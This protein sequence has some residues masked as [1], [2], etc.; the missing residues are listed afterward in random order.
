MPT[1]HR[2]SNAMPSSDGR[3]SDDSIL[4]VSAALTGAKSA[5]DEFTSGDAA[6]RISKV[7]DLVVASIRAGGK[8]L[9]CGNGG[10][11]CDAT[12]FAEELTGRFRADRPALPA[13]AISDAGHITCTAND[14]GFDRVFSRGVEAL[15]KAGDVLIVLST[16]GN[17]K[18][19]VLAV[20]AARAK[21]LSVVA[22]LGKTGG[23]LKGMADVELIAPGATADRIQELHM[24]VLHTIVEGVEAAMF[25]RS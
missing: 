16:S 4:L 17:S 7:I 21:G 9:I 3:P 24:I 1:E 19:V 11:L 18:N 15:G 14:Y 25:G 6:H 23:A 12:H 20:E 22:L 13:I 5:L 8:V 10:S 2:D